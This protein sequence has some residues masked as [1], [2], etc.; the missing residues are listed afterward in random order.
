MIP[1][2]LQIVG[3]V[4]VR[5]YNLGAILRSLTRAIQV[6]MHGWIGRPSAPTQFHFLCGFF[7]FICS[8]PAA[9]GWLVERNSDLIHDAQQ[10]EIYLRVW[11]GWVCELLF[12]RLP[13]WR[14]DLLLDTSAHLLWRHVQLRVPTKTA[15]QVRATR[16]TLRRLLHRLLLP[17]MLS[18]SADQRT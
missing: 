3:L 6:S 5:V 14:W 12:T 11:V 7:I 15:A 1:L 9:S 13:D 18:I 10:L 2:W 8:S 17:P 4:G 16:A